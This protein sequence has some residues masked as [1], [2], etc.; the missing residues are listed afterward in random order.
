MEYLMPHFGQ[1]MPVFCPLENKKA[2]ILLPHGAAPSWP[3]GTAV[4]RIGT[5]ATFRGS[6]RLRQTSSGDTVSYKARGTTRNKSGL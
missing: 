2:F 5:T 1:P 4:D 6:L 3:L